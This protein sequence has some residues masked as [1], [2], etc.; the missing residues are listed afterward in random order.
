M[1]ISE[2]VLAMTF[3]TAQ[4]PSVSIDGM[5]M[6]SATIASVLREAK[7]RPHVKELTLRNVTLDDTVARAAQDLFTAT[8]TPTDTTRMWSKIETIHC[9]G[10]SS[11]II[12]A[13][14][15]RTQQFSFT[16]S[17]PIAHNPRYSLDLSSL[18]AL[19]Q[20]LK[21]CKSLTTL[22]LKGTRL[23]RPGLQAFCAGLAESDSLQTLQM[24]HCAMDAQDV[25]LLAS[26]L[27]QNKHLTAL[28]LA[29]CKWG[30]T[31][32]TTTTTVNPNIN[33]NNYTST[34]NNNEE[35][36][37]A[38][39]CRLLESLVSHPML[40]S[41]NI[42]GI[43]CTPRAMQ[44]LSALLMRGGGAPTSTRTNTTTTTTSSLWHLGLKN[45]LRHPEDKLH[46]TNLLQALE[47]NTSLSYL[48]LSGNNV[49]DDDME[50]LAQIV[51]HSN[52]TLRALSLTANNIGD[53]GIRS[54]ARRLPD[55]TTLR[56][57]DVQRNPFTDDS[58]TEIIAALKY[59]MELERLDLDG[60]WDATKSFY[61][62]LNKG[63]RRL[64]Q[65]GNDTPLGLWP[66]VLERANGLPFGRNQPHAHLDVLYCLVQGPAV[67]QPRRRTTPLSSVSDAH[68]P[69]QRKRAADQDNG[70][71]P[72]PKA[73]RARLKD[74]R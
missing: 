53:A 63:G 28:S 24:S 67:F 5:L 57:L 64:L 25:A 18:Q 4:S 12:Q 47:H 71:Y 70:E 21:E 34:N 50:Q 43:Y 62:R 58:K 35:D 60:T 46:V 19:G 65:S 31:T 2:D 69:H 74:E 38:H 13:T 49:D 59:N 45:N 41:L 33:N 73:K 1:A 66:L 52:D 20:A 10:H 27:A 26:A 22:S 3:T 7:N 39:F 30:P 29:H 68:Q 8:D 44:A 32:T 23:S 17:V 72:S 9:T 37:H 51:T 56:Y 55:M 14:L 6:D 42:Y 61:L 48:Q 15:P 11:R 36:R 40:Q 16:G 54:F